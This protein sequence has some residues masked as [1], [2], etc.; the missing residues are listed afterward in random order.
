MLG[1]V[2]ANTSMY[3]VYFSYYLPNTAGHFTYLP[4]LVDC[5]KYVDTT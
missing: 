1:K 3:V 5:A 2:H 4:I